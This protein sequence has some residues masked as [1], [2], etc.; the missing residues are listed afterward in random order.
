LQR[1]AALI[2]GRGDAMLA[3]RAALI[4]GRGDAMHEQRASTVAS[5]DAD[6]GGRCSLLVPR[7]SAVVG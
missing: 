7:A 6:R 2:R 4:C 3:A 5:V 1:R